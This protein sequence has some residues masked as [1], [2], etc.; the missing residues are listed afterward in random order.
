MDEP[1]GGD[2]SET[3]FDPAEAPARAWPALLSIPAAAALIAL[4]AFLSR[5]ALPASVGVAVDF[6]PALTGIR[7]LGYVAL[8]IGCLILPFW[9]AWTR[10]R[11]RRDRYLRALSQRHLEPVPWWMRVFGIAVLALMLGLQVVVVV[12][13]IDNVRQLAAA[14]SGGR[15]S[16]GPLNTGQIG[17]GPGDDGALVVA[18]LVITAILVIG[19]VLALR[20][21]ILDQPNGVAVPGGTV[22]AAAVSASLDAV[23]NERDPRRAVIAAYVAME[24]TL[25]RAG[26]GRHRSEAP[27][28]YLRRVI[29]APATTAE[30]MR[31]ITA[32]FQHARFSQHTVDESMRSRAVDALMHLRAA[33]GA[34]A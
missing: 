9:V 29:D 15:G 32:L 26:L 1:S 31:T 16:A 33:I 27:F 22:S 3:E 21:R 28:E 12:S 18:L 17:H 11:A 14:G 10:A 2:R 30:D 13:F 23:R 6:E 24:R 34:S 5:S 7:V 8:A 19:V 4:V 25:A 20:W